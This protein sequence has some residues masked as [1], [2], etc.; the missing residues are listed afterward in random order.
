VVNRIVAE[1][2]MRF[3]G[4]AAA[5]QFLESLVVQGKRAL[6]LPEAAVFIF[7]LREHLE[8]AAKANLPAVRRALANP[9][10]SAEV[11]R[12]RRAAAPI[13]DVQFNRQGDGPE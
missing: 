12:L 9:I 6:Q 3:R 11:M 1:P 13:A 5:N 2:V 8:Q 10:A 7:E 4:P